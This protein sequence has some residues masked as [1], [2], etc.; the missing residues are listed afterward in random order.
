MDRGAS[1]PTSEWDGIQQLMQERQAARKRRDFPVADR[2]R[3]TLKSTYN[4]MVDDRTMLWWIESTGSSSLQHPGWAP[5]R[6]IPTYP[7]HDR[8]VDE[9]VVASLLEQRDQARLRKDFKTADALLDQVEHSSCALS[10]K[11]VIKVHDASRTWRVWILNRDARNGEAQASY[12][13]NNT[14]TT[15]TTTRTD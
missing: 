5:W 4:V 15:T 12:P 8:V 1:I 9:T 14:T 10:D 7:K 11:Y 13:K 3:D 6:R 2:I